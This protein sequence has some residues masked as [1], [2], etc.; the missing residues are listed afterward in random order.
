M[1]E[2]YIII[3][4]GSRYDPEA[5]RPHLTV[6]PFPTAEAAIAHM[7]DSFQIQALCEDGAEECATVDAEGAMHWLTIWTKAGEAFELYRIV[8]DDE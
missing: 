5:D 3:D 1:S 7:E 8:A 2:H 6:G 4:R